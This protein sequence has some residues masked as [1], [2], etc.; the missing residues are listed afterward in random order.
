MTADSQSPGGGGPLERRRDAQ[1]IT[2]RRSEP[3]VPGETVR[4][5]RRSKG[6]ASRQL[7]AVI[8]DQGG[9]GEFKSPPLA[10]VAV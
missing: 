7:S 10:F 4:A 9:R 6:H 1:R 3:V 5:K 2:K 8:T